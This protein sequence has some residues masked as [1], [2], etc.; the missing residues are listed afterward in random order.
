M[1][2]VLRSRTSE[3]TSGVSPPCALTCPQVFYCITNIDYLYVTKF[4]QK[5][6][7]SQVRSKYLIPLADEVDVDAHEAISINELNT[8]NR[9]NCINTVYDA[10]AAYVQVVPV[11]TMRGSECF[12]CDQQMCRSLATRSTLASKRIAGRDM[13]NFNYMQ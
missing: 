4:R 1:K 2:N 5:K 11:Q 6:I 13:N 10:R 9:R 8:A 3:K 12:M 7:F